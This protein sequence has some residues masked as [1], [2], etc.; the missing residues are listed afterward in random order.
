MSI[1]AQRVRKISLLL[2]MLTLTIGCEKPSKIVT[3]KPPIGDGFT[4]YTIETFHGHG[5]ISD[6]FTRIY[7]H[8]PVGDKVT[9]ELVADGP[10]IEDSKVL[11]ID[12]DDVS[13]C[14]PN[15]AHVNTFHNDTSLTVGSVSEMKHNHLQEHC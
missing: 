10:Y 7:A 8:F 13:I 2:A 11:W 9:T 4:Y 5:A 12:S 6:D 3:F 15:G 1:A 14:I